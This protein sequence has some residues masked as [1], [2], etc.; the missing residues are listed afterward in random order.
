MQSSAESKS[1]APNNA[2]RPSLIIE[3]YLSGT[4]NLSGNQSPASVTPAAPSPDPLKT[5]RETSPDRG[6]GHPPPLNT[7][8][9]FTLKQRKN[10]FF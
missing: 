5:T 10:T 7:P 3:N 9:V 4:D 1:D 6:R 2:S 8:S